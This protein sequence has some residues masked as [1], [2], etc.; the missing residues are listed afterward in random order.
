MQIMAPMEMEMEEGRGMVC[1]WNSF[2][3][4][5]VGTLVIHIATPCG[6]TE[7][8]DFGGMATRAEFFTHFIRSYAIVF[9]GVISK[10]L[11]F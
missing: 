8:V 5:A 11:S 1:S 7:C 4:W 6:G 2:V 10:S 3:S 9:F